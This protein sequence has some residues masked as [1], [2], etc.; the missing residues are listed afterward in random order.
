M[1]TRAS[2]ASARAISTTC[3]WPRRRSATRV[4]GSICSSRRSS[5]GSGRL[6]L[7]P[8]V[9]DDAAAHE[10]AAHEDVVA[11]AQVGREAEF[12]V[13]DRD[14]AARR[15]R[16]CCAAPPARRR[17]RARPRSGISTPLRIFMSVDLPAPF[18]PNST[19]TDAAAHLEVDALERVGRAVALGDADCAHH[20][21][22]ASRS[23]DRPRSHGHHETSAGF[24][25]RNAPV[26]R[27]VLPSAA[28]ASNVR[29][30]LLA[31]QVV[32]LGADLLVLELVG[33]LVER[34]RAG[35]VAER[36]AVERRADLDLHGG[37]RV[38]A[39]RP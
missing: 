21:V 31:H 14:A 5:S 37:R 25:R 22:G 28:A 39:R 34:D 33:E 2:P 35:D 11:H 19:V 23:P 16:P 20:D 36:R 15:R 8:L 38:D 10:L 27:M 7:A 30:H 18:S 9:D 1:S 26:T 29:E 17:A 3:C 13:D 6:R 12:L 32:Q 4:R 24:T